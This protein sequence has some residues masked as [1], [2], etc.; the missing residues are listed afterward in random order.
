MTLCLL[1]ISVPTHFVCFST[2]KA[3][4]EI[5]RVRYPWVIHTFPDNEGLG[6]A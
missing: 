3:L 4:Q 6:K 5:S 2:T 1:Q